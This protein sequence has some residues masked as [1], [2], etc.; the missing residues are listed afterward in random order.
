M[1]VCYIG[2]LHVAGVW[3][4]AY[5]IIQVISIVPDSQFFNT[6]SPPTLLPAQCLSFPSLCPHVLNVLLPLITEN[7]QYLIFFLSFFRQYLALSPGWS[8]GADLSSLQPLPPGF[9]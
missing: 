1:Q 7:M 6:H 8:A 5:F 3:Y 9:K 4:T 2:K